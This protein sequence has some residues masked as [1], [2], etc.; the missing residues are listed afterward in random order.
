VIELLQAGPLTTVQDLGRTGWRHLGVPSGG[1]MDSLALQQANALLG[2][3]PGAAALEFVGGQIRIR[4]ERD[5]WVMQAGALFAL[6]IDGKP[7]APYLRRFVR[8]GQCLRLQGPMT[9]QFGLLAVQ[10]GLDLPMQMG[11]RATLMRAGLGGHEGRALRAGDR[12]PLGPAQG[13]QRSVGL[14]PSVSDGLLGLL[15]G[16]EWGQL[17]TDSRTA[18]WQADWALLPQ[19]DRMGL[20][21]SGPK[22][23][24]QGFDL[25]SYAAFPGLVQLPPDGLPIVLAVD[26]QTTGGYPRIG[27][28]IASDLWKLAQLRPGDRLQFAPV[29]LDTARQLQTAQ[30]EELHAFRKLLDAL[31]R[32]QR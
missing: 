30:V 24:R 13:L 15:P 23:R 1:A 8:A 21:L 17:D 7:Q 27:Q 3:A 25:L 26:A 32:P 31:D 29:D 6:D 12:L 5:T 20:R 2:N 9:G 14:H 19:S 18:F 28:I 16:P 22:L 11:S 4:F 10:G